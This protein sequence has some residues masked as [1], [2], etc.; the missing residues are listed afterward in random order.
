M[1]RDIH[2]GA[3]Q[4]LVAMKIKLG[5]AKTLLRD[6]PDFVARLLDD[7]AAESTEAISTLRDLARGLFPQ[8]L[9]ERGLVAALESHIAKSSIPAVI[10][11]RDEIGPLE[12]QAEA[13]V[14]FVLREAL[15]NVSKYAPE[16]TIR[17]ELART[18]GGALRFRVCDD[19]PGFDPATAKQGSGTQNMR[20]RIEALGGRFSVSSAPGR[21]TEVGGEVPLPAPAGV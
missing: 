10:D 8:V 4:Q 9:V 5:L 2:D 15:Q 16:A 6:D 17:I 7:L 21:G 11:V 14:Y 1:E 3:Q 18:D 19:G 13:N 20:D 12:P